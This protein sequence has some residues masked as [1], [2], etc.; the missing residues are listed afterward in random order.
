[1]ANAV[2]DYTP[3]RRR[4]AFHKKRPAYLR[5]VPSLGRNRQRGRLAHALYA[6]TYTRDIRANTEATREKPYGPKWFRV[7][8]S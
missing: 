4:C 1:M 2:S 5:R 7:V 3:P 8:S 6:A